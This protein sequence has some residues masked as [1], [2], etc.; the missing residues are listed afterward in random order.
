MDTQN[1]TTE[2]P[3]VFNR[4]TGSRI[5][6]KLVGGD[7]A[8]RGFEYKVFCLSKHHNYVIT[9]LANHYDLSH[10]KV[11]GDVIQYYIDLHRD[12]VDELFV[13]S[14]SVKKPSR[15]TTNG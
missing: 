15:F 4:S 12:E 9:K 10:G 1:T 2:L 6:P 3:E 14:T 8:P 5:Q 7:E 11:L 13:S